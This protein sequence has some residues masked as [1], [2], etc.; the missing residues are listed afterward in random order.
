MRLGAPDAALTRFSGLAAVTELIDRLGIIDKLDAA[1]GPIKDRDRGCSAG[2]MLVGM[3]AAQLCGEDFLVGLDRHRADTAGQALTPVPGLASTTAAGLARKFIEG[4][5]A[6]VETGLGDVHTTALDLLAQVDPDRAE[7]LTADVTIDLDTT[8]VEVYGRLKQGVAFNHQGQRVARPHV[9]TWAD[10]AVVLAADL[11]SGR[12]DPRATSAELFHRALAALPAQA[13]AG[14]VRVRADAGYFAGQLARAALFVGVEFAIG[15]RRI[16][17]L[18]RI[19]DGVAADGWTDA[20]DMTGAQVA[21]ADYCPNWWPAATQLLIR[22]VRLDLDHGQVSGDPRARRRRTLYPAQRALPLDDL[23][24][25]AKVDG[26]FAY[27]FIVTNLDVSTPAAAA[28]AE[29]WYRHRTKVE[30]LFRDTKHGAALR[31]LPS[32]HLAVNRAWMWGALL[33]ATTSGWLHHLTAR[34]RDGRLVGHG[35]R[36][37]QAMIATLRRRLITIPARLVRHA[38]GLTLRLPPGEHLLAEVLAR[39]RALPAPS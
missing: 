38:R 1:V 15:A 11:G 27:S 24:T 8:D 39:V 32:G 20:I 12:D 23:A 18:W 33:A 31:H 21:V 34:T 3:S 9:A 14:R 29:Y 22:R 10:T 19:L 6:A 13:R 5:W 17:P 36:G 4:Q 30:N 28:Q 26:V 25:V 35:V 37:G 16:A 2:Q 7:Q